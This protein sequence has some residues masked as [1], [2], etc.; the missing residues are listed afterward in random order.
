MRSNSLPTCCWNTGHTLYTSLPKKK[1]QVDIIHIK[2]ELQ[3]EKLYVEKP[4]DRQPRRRE[5]DARMRGSLWTQIFVTKEAGSKGR[6]PRQRLQS[7]AEEAC[8]R[9]Q[10][11]SDCVPTDWGTVTRPLTQGILKGIE[12][13]FSTN[14][15]NFSWERIHLQCM[16]RGFNLSVGKISWRRERLPT[17]VFW[18]GELHGL[19]SP[20]LHKELDTTKWLSLLH[21]S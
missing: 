1:K 3:R 6:D 18:P 4:F 20:W 12:S 15:P 7:W 11:S 16:K 8:S 14:L 2:Q 13:S 9:R 19:Y 17:P 5:A 21:L 10:G